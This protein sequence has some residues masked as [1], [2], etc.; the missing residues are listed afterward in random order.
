MSTAIPIGTNI[1]DFE[2]LVNLLMHFA[3]MC[4]EDIIA[5]GKKIQIQVIF[6]ETFCQQSLEIATPKYLKVMTS[7]IS[8]YITD[9]AC[10]RR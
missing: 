7:H 4:S 10:I 5:T 8:Q 1:M 3:I 2:S 9:L 6:Y